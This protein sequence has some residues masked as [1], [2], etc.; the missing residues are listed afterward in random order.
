MLILNKIVLQNLNTDNQGVTL[1]IQN[2]K[3]I[4]QD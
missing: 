4:I 1:V 3:F 2:S